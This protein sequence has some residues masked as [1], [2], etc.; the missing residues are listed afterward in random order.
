M[1]QT[2]SVNLCE[3]YKLVNFNIPN[4]LIKNFD[5]LVKFKRVSRTSML[6]HLI[7]RFIRFELT[8]LEK[9]KKLSQL[10]SD[11]EIRN[12]ENLKHEIKK[13]IGEIEDEQGPPMV[14]YQTDQ[15]FTQRKT[16]WEESY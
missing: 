5:H 6:I 4:Y 8:E 7:D 1:N 16:G 3:S 9:D 12:R 11:V 14:P 13:T 15:I 2:H 10:I